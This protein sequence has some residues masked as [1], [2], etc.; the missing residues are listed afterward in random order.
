MSQSISS[1]INLTTTPQTI[2]N[3]A[4][5]N[6]LRIKGIVCALGSANRI[7]LS[8]GTNVLAEI[9]C[10]ANVS[11]YVPFGDDGLV[12][13]SGVDLLANVAASTSLGIFTIVYD[14]LDFSP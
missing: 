3:N 11:V 1:V 5:S 10:G 6:Q 12:L 14:L 7:A 8:D 4:G 2:L 13:G 9:V